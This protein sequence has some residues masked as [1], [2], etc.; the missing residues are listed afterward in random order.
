MMVRRGGA[1]IRLRPR[2]RSRAAG[3]GRRHG[4]CRRRASSAPRVSSSDSDVPQSPYSAPHTLH[5]HIHSLILTCQI[6]SS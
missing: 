5:S 6:L 2:G 3:S 1:V 4:E